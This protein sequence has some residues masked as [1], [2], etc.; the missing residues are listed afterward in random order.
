MSF[1]GDKIAAAEYLQAGIPADQA[2]R[3]AQ[4]K[5]LED[6][7]HQ[8]CYWAA[9]VHVGNPASTSNPIYEY[10]I[11]NLSWEWI[12]LILLI[13]LFGYAAARRQPILSND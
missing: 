3:T 2:L 5:Y 4:I 1:W 7:K 13:S 10:R 11:Y 9:I 12:L 8:P 6:G